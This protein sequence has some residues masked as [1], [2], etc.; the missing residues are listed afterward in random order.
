ML[1]CCW[2]VCVNQLVMLFVQ[3][4]VCA[5]VF[6]S[7]II[8]SQILRFVGFRVKELIVRELVYEGQRGCTYL[9]MSETGS[10]WLCGYH[11]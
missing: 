8:L 7:R 4:A 1:V 3:V 6:F 5:M 2:D 9:T 10:V 11:G